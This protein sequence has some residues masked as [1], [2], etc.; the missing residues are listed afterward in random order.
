MKDNSAESSIQK[1]APQGGYRTL[2]CPNL[3]DPD[4]KREYNKNHF[5]V[6][7]RRYDVATKGLSLLQDKAW[8]KQLVQAIPHYS[9][10]V[11][12]D[13]ACG[14]GD[15]CFEI[16]KKFPDAEII[17]MDITPEMLKAL[18]ARAKKTGVAIRTIEGD[19]AQL[20]M[21]HTSVDVVT[22]GYALRNSPYLGRTIVE[23]ARVLRHGGTFAILDFAKPEGF[24]AQRFQQNIMAV[25]G[26][27]WGLLLHANPRV[28]GYISSSLKVYPKQE[29]VIQLIEG[30]GFILENRKKLLFG[31]TEILV[32]KRS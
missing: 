9:A 21:S 20:P 13:L 22:A 8:K 25:W 17:G 12:L 32:F 15:I 31:S 19:I 2:P 26:G 1:T 14:T 30:S 5:G 11:V 18:E 16:A 24:I 10:P 23:V 27:L 4:L 28:H 7:A 6:A 3:A 29:L